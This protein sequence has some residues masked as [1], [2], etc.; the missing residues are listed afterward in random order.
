MIVIRDQRQ[1]GE[2]MMTSKSAFAGIARSVVGGAIAAAIAAGSPA[3]AAVSYD[4]TASGDLSNS[5]ST[6]TIVSFGLGD[7]IVSG[8]S[9]QANSVIDRDYFTFTLAAGQQLNAIEV[10]TGTTSIG[11]GTL[12]FIGIQSGTQMTV[13]PASFSATGLL[14]WTHYGPGD[15]GTDILGEMGIG[16]GATGFT[17]PLGSGSYTVWVQEAN[18]GTANYRFNFLVGSVPEPSTWAMMLAGFGLIG[19]AMRRRGVQNS[20]GPSSARS[21]AM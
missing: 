11:P 20:R 18:V 2:V 16:A 14:G 4:E 10:L 7:N 9:G 1:T 19:I 13:D 21:L 12:S 15:I 8:A 3:L 5:R 6:P 17:P